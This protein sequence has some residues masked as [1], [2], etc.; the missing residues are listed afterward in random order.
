MFSRG[1]SRV[2]STMGDG[3]CGICAM[4]TEVKVSR[5]KIREAVAICD[6]RGVAVG[7]LTCCRHLLR[8]RAATRETESLPREV[9]ESHGRP[10]GTRTPDLYRV[11]P[12]LFD[13]TP[14]YRCSR[15][16]LTPLSACKFVRHRVGLRVGADQT[17]Y[18]RSV[19]PSRFPGGSWSCAL[20]EQGQKTSDRLGTGW[21]RGPAQ[22]RTRL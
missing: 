5:T 16:L 2:C 17:F 18:A 14:T 19:G 9:V 4:R 7:I 21:S 10:V 13:F 20:I 6:S 11:K 12:Q 8:N 22:Y 15:G 3:F 1:C